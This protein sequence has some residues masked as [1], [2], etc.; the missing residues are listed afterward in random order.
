MNIG[1]NDE[2]FHLR[3]MDPQS[4]PTKQE[5]IDTIALMKTP[6]DWQ[7][8]VPFMFGLNMS[9]RFIKPDRWEWVIRHANNQA[10]ALGV[11]VECAKQAEITGFRLNNAAVVQ[12]LFFELHRKAQRGG[13]QE[14]ALGKALRLANQILT[15][16]EAPEHIEHN[17]QL[18]P[19]RK[20]IVVGVLL[21]LNAARALNEFGGKDEG[22]HVMAYALRLLGTWPNH[23]FNRETKKWA[24]VDQQLLENV[25]IYNGLRLALQFREITQ[26]KKILSLLK[27]HLNMMDMWIKKHKSAADE[28]VQQQLTQGLEQAQ[29]LYKS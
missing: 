29:L 17:L 5:A 4:R 6:S 21:E 8:L 19:K 13:F 9:H 11:I 20:P 25:P 23:P 3:P 12:R 18:D 7:N 1:A 16:M 24:D 10:D 2:P 27:N 22:G 26:D 14:P 15:L 28:K